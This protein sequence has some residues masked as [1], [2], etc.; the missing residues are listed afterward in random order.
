MIWP[1]IAVKLPIP[2]C[3]MK[4]VQPSQCAV[5]NSKLFMV[6]VMVVWLCLLVGREEVNPRPPDSTMVCLRSHHSEDGPYH[7]SVCMS[8]H[9]CKPKCHWEDIRNDELQGV[10]INSCHSTGSLELMVNLVDM[11]IEE[12]VGMHQPVTV[13]EKNLIGYD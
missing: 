5:I 1:E 6:K 11:G 13:K 7:P 8:V 3:T 9:A 10:A 2:R 4:I 12:L